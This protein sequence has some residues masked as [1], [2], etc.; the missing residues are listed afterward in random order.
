MTITGSQFQRSHRGHVR[1]ETNAAFKINSPCPITATSP[2]GTGTV[3]VTVTTP[4]GT[5]KQQPPTASA[6]SSNRRPSKTPR[7]RLSS[8]TESQSTPLATTAPGQSSVLATT[9]SSSAI[10]LATTTLTVQ[11]GR[12]AV[13]LRCVSARTCTST[14]TLAF[15]LHIHRQ[16]KPTTTRLQTIGRAAFSV[17]AG[18]TT[19]VTVTLNATGRALLNAAHGKLDALLTILR[20]AT[21]SSSNQTKAVHLRG[22]TSGAKKSGSR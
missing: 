19:A 22:V 2:A 5:S 9:T 13:K 6:T 21:A 10:V 4:G 16:G 14:L 15:K 8:T 7:R 1:I 18:Q 17:R 11:H 3:D 12:A 20:S